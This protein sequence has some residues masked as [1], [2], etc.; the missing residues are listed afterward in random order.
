MGHF[1]VKKHPSRSLQPFPVVRRCLFPVVHCSVFP[2]V[3][4]SVFPAFSQSFIAAFTQSFIAAFSQP[5]PS[6]S[7]QRFHSLFPVVHYSLFPVVHCSKQRVLYRV[8]RRNSPQIQ[9]SKQC[10]L[11]TE[12]PDEVLQCFIAGRSAFSQQNVLMKF[13]SVSLQLL[14][15][16]YPSRTS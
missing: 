16:Y 15:V 4:R 10:A 11:Q 13:S 6:R 8:S 7:L 3:H 9:F 1:R 14:A 12:R 5:F 2:V